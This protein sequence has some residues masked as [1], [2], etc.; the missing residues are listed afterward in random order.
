M[1]AYKIKAVVSND[2][3]IMLKEIPFHKGETVEVILLSTAGKEASYTLR[4]LPL[5][6]IDPTEPVAGNDWHNQCIAP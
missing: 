4:G 6:Y 2:G 1:E 3:E 5:T